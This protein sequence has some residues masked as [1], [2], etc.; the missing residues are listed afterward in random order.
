MTQPHAQPRT[1]IVIPTYRRSHDLALCLE[2]IEQLTMPPTEILVVYRES[3]DP[4]TTASIDEWLIGEG[5]APRRAVPVGVPGVIAA[6][7]AGVRETACDVIAFIDDDVRVQPEWLE[8]CLRHYASPDV[9]GVGGRDIVHDQ[10]FY[11]PAAEVGRI[12]WFGRMVGNHHVG[13]GTARPVDLLKGANLSMR[14]S[15]LQFDTRLRGRGAQ[16]HWEAQVSL[17][18]RRAGSRLIYDPECVVDHYPAPRF[19]ADRRMKPQT[20]AVEDQA[21]NEVYV[22]LSY[23]RWWQRLC[24]L[25]YTFLVGHRASLGLVRWL[26]LELSGQ[27]KST[28]HYLLPALRGKFAGIITWH[29]AE[30]HAR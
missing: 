26:L 5:I 29:R 7:Q 13:Y 17:W 25:P 3:G 18:A 15:F 10:E 4:D 20:R 8:R 16:V 11:L 23:L 14:R 19:D 9:A 24:Y 27:G 30:R 12:R 22:V 6:M 21:H 1:A 2:A 28:R